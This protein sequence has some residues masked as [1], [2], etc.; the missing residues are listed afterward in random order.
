MYK[1]F[2][3]SYFYFYLGLAIYQ[4]AS[5]LMAV[6]NFRSI[7]VS[8]VHVW[9]YIVKKIIIPLEFR[10]EPKPI[11]HQIWV[12][13]NFGMFFFLCGLTFF[14]SGHLNQLENRVTIQLNRTLLL[15]KII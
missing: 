4:V 11:N 1:L 10:P 15:K 7:I 12:R 2:K 5:K 14:W 8:L 13:L 3:I 6:H 9:A